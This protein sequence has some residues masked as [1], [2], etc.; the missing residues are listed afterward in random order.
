MTD[1]AIAT[2]IAGLRGDIVQVPSAVSA[3]KVDGQR[4]YRLAREGH[5]S[6]W[7]RGRCAS[8]GSRCWPYA[9]TTT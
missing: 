4:A 5:P 8:T 6:N 1:E 7:P 2:A 3:I 9:A